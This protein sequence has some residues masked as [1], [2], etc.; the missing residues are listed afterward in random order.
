MKHGKSRRNAQWHDGAPRWVASVVE[1]Q[2]RRCGSGRSLSATFFAQFCLLSWL[3]PRPSTAGRVEGGSFGGEGA[4]SKEVRGCHPWEPRWKRRTLQPRRGRTPPLLFDP[5]LTDAS[6]SICLLV[7]QGPAMKQ[8]ETAWAPP[9]ETEGTSPRTVCSHAFKQ[10][11][12]QPALQMTEWTS[13]HKPEH[14][15][16]QPE[17]SQRSVLLTPTGSRTDSVS[18]LFLSLTRRIQYLRHCRRLVKL[19]S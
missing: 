19:P 14:C 12:R 4:S 8:R 5:V 1:V 3:H 2:P 7:S 13:G 18:M 10:P 17:G 9:P 11:C 6:G 16:V 15:S